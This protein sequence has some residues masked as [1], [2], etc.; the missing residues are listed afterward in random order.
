MMVDVSKTPSAAQRRQ[1]STLV[2]Q[3]ALFLFDEATNDFK[4]SNEAFFVAK[5]VMDGDTH[6]KLFKAQS[7]LLKPYNV[8]LPREPRQLPDIGHF[9]KTVSNGLYM[10]GNNNKALKGV[11]LL[12]PSRIQAIS[13]DVA[14]HLRTYNNESL[15]HDKKDGSWKDEAWHQ[16]FK[17][18]GLIVPHHS[19]NG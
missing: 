14:K 1:R 9:I 4:P 16:C 15:N 5:M 19:G 12:E 11:S 18:I 7:E 10:L 3:R 17:A 2:K 8:T 13:S 6:R